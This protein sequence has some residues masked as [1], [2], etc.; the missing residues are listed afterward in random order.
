[1]TT[2]FV[3]SGGGS[4]GSIQVGM[5]HALAE[6]GFRPDL[7]IGTSAG[8]LNAGFIASNGFS[9][10]TID[11][12]GDLWRS[13]RRRDVFPVG[14]ARALK[15][16][17][18]ASVAIASGAGLERLVAEHIRCPDLESMHIELH[19]VVTELLS[20]HE[21]LL[22]EG[23]A[24]S[25]IIASASV[26][27]LLPPVQREGRLFAD[28]GITNNTGISHAVALGADR[29]V[30]LPTGYACAL[31]RP[32]RSALAAGLHA[33]TLLIQRRLIDDVS[34]A[35]T[36]FDLMVLPPL[37]PL[38]VSAA[39]FTQAD[40][41]IDRARR[42]AGSWIDSGNIALPGQERFLSMHGHAPIAPHNSENI[43]QRDLAIE[44]SIRPPRRETTR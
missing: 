14:P 23:D 29:I 30:V 24:A 5:L 1:M 41:L 27:A 31:S 12:L 37:C 19:V 7:L 43:D 16:M 11:R 42:A 25:A 38:T 36:H 22:S 15:S 6:R 20:G 35:P 13:L 2:A 21:V 4:L 44:D 17:L 8:A 34:D 18:G 39:N 32:P 9:P 3:L 10:E 40:L 28:G 33:L 26:P